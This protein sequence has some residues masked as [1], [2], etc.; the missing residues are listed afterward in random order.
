MLSE[1]VSEARARG[2]GLRRRGVPEAAGASGQGVSG[3]ADAASP[4]RRPRALRHPMHAS[5]AA[6]AATTAAAAAETL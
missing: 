6:A 2:G 5:T 4:D 1:D 3:A